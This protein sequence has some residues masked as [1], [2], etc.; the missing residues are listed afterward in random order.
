VLAVFAGEPRGP[1]N[2]DGMGSAASFWQPAAVASDGAGNVYVADANN[3]TIRKITPEGTV[4]TFAGTAGPSG[5]AD[6]TG[7]A[8]TFSNPAALATDRDGN[9]YVADTYNYTVRKITPDGVVST[10]AGTPGVP[11][12]NN[13]PVATA[14]FGFIF[15]I[16]VDSNGN[17]Y[18]AQPFDTVIRQI[19]PAGMVSTWA[20][21][22]IGGT[23]DGPGPMASFNSPR[24]LAIDHA[25]NLYV[26]DTYGPVRRITPDDVVSTIWTSAGYGEVDGPVATAQ[27]SGPYGIA[28]DANGDVFIADWDGFTV[29]KLSTDGVVTTIAGVGFMGGDVDGVGSVT[30]LAGPQGVATDPSGN[31]FIADTGNNAIRKV[32][33]DGTVSTFAGPVIPATSAGE[34]PGASSLAINPAGGLYVGFSIWLYRVTSSG[35]ASVFAGGNLSGEADG[36]GANAGFYSLLGLAMSPGGSLYV[37]DWA[38]FKRDPFP[39]SQTVTNNAIRAVSPAAAVTTFAGGYAPGSANGLGTQAQFNKPMG[40]ATD[41]SGNIYVADSQ[42]HTIRRITAAGLVSTL[43]GVAGS[44]GYGD[45]P[46]P[47]AHF[48]SPSGVAV[49]QGGYIY[50]ADTGNSVIRRISSMGV[51]STLAGMPGVTGSADGPGTAARFNLPQGITTDSAGNAYVADTQNSTVRKVTISG[52]VTTLAGVA[53]QAGFVSGALPGRIARPLSVATSG[54]SLYITS[55]NGV[56]VVRNLP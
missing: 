16:A 30:R 23:A 29:R 26:A 39:D 11:G 6:G 34:L 9:V 53:G 14:T 51:V 25:D 37:S 55:N 32:T 35:E 48:S 3:N 50:V 18:V 27:F 38:N 28:V 47:S 1:G 42:N 52:D 41:G 49:G 20:G 45:G 4:S 8:A 36:V 31:V 33:P 56:V 43:A 17:V 21:T 24:G 19:T 10:L 15:G 2:L 13:G 54:G 7:A 40:V 22:G 46:G 12:L 5:H 44:A